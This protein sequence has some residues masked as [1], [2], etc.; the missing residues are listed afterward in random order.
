MEIARAGLLSLSISTGEIWVQEWT[1]IETSRRGLYFPG[2]FPRKKSRLHHRSG[3]RTVT[4]WC[5]AELVVGIYQV[6]RSVRLPGSPSPRLRLARWG[7]GPDHRPTDPEHSSRRFLRGT[8]VTSATLGLVLCLHG[9][10]VGGAHSWDRDRI[11]V[12]RGARTESA[13]DGAR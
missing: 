11:W 3:T 13:R 10:A 6:H 8:A 4:W 1:E 7:P 9:G 2:K 12:Q 5:R